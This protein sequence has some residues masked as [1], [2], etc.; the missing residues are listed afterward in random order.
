MPSPVPNK[1]DGDVN[2]PTVPYERISE[3]GAITLGKRVVYLTQ[4][5][6]LA[7]TLAA[8]TDPDMDGQSIE[9]IAQTA[10]AHIVVATDLINGNNDKLTWGGAIGDSA[11]LYADGGEWFTGMLVN[12]TVGTI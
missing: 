12:V 7:V 10:H 3:D 8:P 5:S 4:A 1:S 6:T 11:T 9:I 2:M